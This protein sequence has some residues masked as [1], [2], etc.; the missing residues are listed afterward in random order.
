M[1]QKFKMVGPAVAIARR[2]GCGGASRIDPQWALVKRTW[3][4]EGSLQAASAWLR[5]FGR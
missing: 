2:P 5:S 4:C 3:V 1:N